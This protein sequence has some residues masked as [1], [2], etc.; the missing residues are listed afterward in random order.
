MHPLHVRTLLAQG[1]LKRAGTTQR[2]GAVQ[3]HYTIAA[4]AVAGTR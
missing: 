4:K 1:L 3:H 2:R